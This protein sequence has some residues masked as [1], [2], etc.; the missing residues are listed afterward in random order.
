MPWNFLVILSYITIP[1]MVVVNKI[2]IIWGSNSEF[3]LRSSINPKRNWLSC[4][5]PPEWQ[6]LNSS[7]IIAFARS[8]LSADFGK[9]LS[10]DRVCN[11]IF[12]EKENVEKNGNKRITGKLKLQTRHRLRHKFIEVI[13]IYSALKLS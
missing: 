4:M 2:E 8:I 13:R 9:Y 7:Y 10:S 1:C 5:S 12:N 6:R 11:R 3:V